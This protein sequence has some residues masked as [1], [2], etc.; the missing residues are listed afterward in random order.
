MA[1]LPRYQQ[2]GLL[3]ADTTRLD[4]ADIKESIGLSKGIS[5]SLDR[6]SNF[7]FKEA[8]E[9]AQREGMQW[10]AENQPGVEQVMAA[11]E[12][13]KSPAELF[14]KPGTMFGDAARKVQAAQLRVELE[15]RGRQDLAKLSAAIEAGPVDI[16]EVTTRIKGL[17][18]GYG[19]ALASIDPEESLKFRASIG[20]AGNAV[21]TKAT[22][23]AAKMY[24][25]Q[26]KV[27][28]KDSLASTSGIL[29]DTISSEAD[30][31]MLLQRVRIERQRVMDIATQVGDV[32]FFERTM[33]DFDQKLV[34]SMVE[35]LGKPE[36][37][38]NSAEVFSRLQTG[39]VGKLSEIYKTLNK[40]D[41]IAGYMKRVSDNKNIL[42]ANRSVERLQN[43]GTVNNLLIEYYNPNTSQVRKRDIGL[44]IARMNVLSV[45]QMERFL[46]PDVK[47]GD[48]V[49]YSNLQYKVATGVITDLEEL[50]SVSVRSGFSGKQYTALAD[51]LISRTK[52]DETKAYK[53]VGAA[54]G[55][56][57]V[58]PGRSKNNEHQ[59]KKEQKILEYYEEAKQA[60]ILETGSFNPQAVAQIAIDR[61]DNTDRRNIQ[62]K[63]AQD[64][65]DS[66]AK[67]IKARK[68]I[69]T[70]FVLNAETNPEDLLNSK[71]I[72]N[73]EYTAIKKNIDILRQE[74][75]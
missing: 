64:K 71:I 41:V 63:S 62:K 53:M 39:N 26:L 10:A 12:S 27:L 73:D 18:D 30:P 31:A 21:Y 70:E 51:K 57:D 9:Q 75:Q 4:F 33:K 50:R 69:K 1:E 56:G 65:L 40:N 24:S 67:D 19:K 22:E 13:G 61:Y 58:R 14:S 25:E 23:R 6:L 28:A 43:E 2:T 17:T 72:S 16:K 7:A 44:N 32:Q 52:S 3:P 55:F 5:S 34:D 15:A 47:D 48:P 11:L 74:A 29:N 20:T 8:G 45:D 59:F 42:E 38:K 66:M 49:A 35:H 37:S 68:K 46:N 60:S 36:V 54:S